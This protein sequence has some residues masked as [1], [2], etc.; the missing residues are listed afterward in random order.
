ME[1]QLIFPQIESRK[2]KNT[3]R[4]EPRKTMI[5]TKVIIITTR[6]NKLV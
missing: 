3:Q 5:L 4:H 2:P 1:M 6:E